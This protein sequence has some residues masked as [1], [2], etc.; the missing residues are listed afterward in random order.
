MRIGAEE[1]AAAEL[2]DPELADQRRACAGEE[3]LAAHGRDAGDV[4]HG[5]EVVGAIGFSKEEVAWVLGV[6]VR[7]E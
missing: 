5:D 3:G 1:R 2:L 6:D 4:C 7:L